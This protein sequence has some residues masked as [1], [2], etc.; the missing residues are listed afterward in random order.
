MRERFACIVLTGL[1][2]DESMVPGTAGRGVGVACHCPRS[3]MTDTDDH[4]HPLDPGRVN[5]MDP[6]ELAYWCRELG[7]TPERLQ[8]AVAAAGEHVTAVREWLGRPPAG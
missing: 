8:S 6:V 5:T 4:F 7:C 2:G 1:P 3:T